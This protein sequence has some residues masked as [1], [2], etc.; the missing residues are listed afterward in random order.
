MAQDPVRADGG[1]EFNRPTIV[2]L[3]YL[4]S[5]VVGI[6][7]LV[8]IILAYIWEGEP[9]EAWEESHWRWL[10]RTFW[11]GLLYG[12]IAGALTIGT[13][14]LGGFVFIPLVVVWFAVRAIRSL[15]A[16]QK[17]APMENVETWLF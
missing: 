9:N 4:L 6:T 15:L 17:R 16:A 7:I 10:I 5:A 8:G 3:L 14:G 1:F 11:I 12:V 13:F 2:S